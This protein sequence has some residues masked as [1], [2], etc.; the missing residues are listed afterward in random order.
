MHPGMPFFANPFMSPFMPQQPLDTTPAAPTAPA[1]TV[2]TQGFM[3]SPAQYQEMMQQYFQQMMMASQLG[4]TM[5][6]P[7]PFAAPMPV[8]PSSQV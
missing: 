3:F 2:P 5:P 4:Q 8:R 1:V 7:M 6:F